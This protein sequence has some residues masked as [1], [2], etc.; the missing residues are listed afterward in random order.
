VEE[1]LVPDMTSL[2]HAASTVVKTVCVAIESIS[3]I[4]L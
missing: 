2:Y 4:T 3:K 1:W